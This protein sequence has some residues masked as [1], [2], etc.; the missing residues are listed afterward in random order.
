MLLVFG[1]VS[2]PMTHAS[3][4]GLRRLHDE[5]G[6]VVT[7]VTLNVR[8][9]HPGEHLEQPQTLNAKRSHARRL[10]QVSPAPWETLVDP[11]EGP[12]HRRLAPKPN[13]AFLLA[14]DRTILFRALWAGD[15][16]G[17]R[18]A[19]LAARAGRP[20]PRP[21]STAAFRPLLEGLGYFSPSLARSG[22]RA[23]R[24]LLVAAPPVA[25]LAWLAALFPNRAPHRR[26][27]FAVALALGL[28]ALVT[29]LG[30]ALLREA[31]SRVYSPITSSAPL[32]VLDQ[33]VT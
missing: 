4:A 20:P 14:P 23:R 31:S 5:F 28:G 7:F 3:S 9:A 17:L 11:L 15:E 8:E 13:A 16:R 19:L 33:V 10:A 29:L 18:A 32:V 6:D 26:G 1:S 27:H 12:L 24:E 21:Q 2:C 30:W 22:P 25:L